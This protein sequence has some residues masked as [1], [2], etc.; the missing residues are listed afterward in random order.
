MAMLWREPQ[1][2]ELCCRPHL[3][4]GPWDSET[5]RYIL[6]IMY[7]YPSLENIEGIEELS[8]SIY[9]HEKKNHILYI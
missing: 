9:C 7:M 5:Q 3:R 4:T 1:L 6:L 8:F 2:L